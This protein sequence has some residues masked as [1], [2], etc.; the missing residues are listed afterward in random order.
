MLPSEV[1]GLF[2]VGSALSSG[3]AWVDALGARS[4]ARPE[5]EEL[6]ARLRQH[7]IAWRQVAVDDSLPVRLVERLRDLPAIPQ[8]LLLREGALLQPIGQRLPF[9]VLHDQEVD[10][11]P[12]RRRHGGRRC[13]DA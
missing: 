10:A 8:D 3:A 2:S 11:I 4:F 1:S 7:D 9:E 13:G 6:R 12:A 5:V